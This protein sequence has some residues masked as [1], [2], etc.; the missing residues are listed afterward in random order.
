[1]KK[2]SEEKINEMIRDENLGYE[3][4]KSY[5]LNNLARDEKKHY[6]YLIKLRKK[7]YGY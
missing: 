1:M 2:I 3:E 4:Y 7:W 6:N 5:G